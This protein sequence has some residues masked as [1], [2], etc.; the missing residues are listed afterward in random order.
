M[1]VKIKKKFDSA[2]HKHIVSLLYEVEQIMEE[3]DDMFLWH[4]TFLVNQKH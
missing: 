2:T 3:R 4:N 1:Y